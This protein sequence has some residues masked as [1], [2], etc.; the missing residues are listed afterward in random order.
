MASE[1][2]EKG[3]YKGYIAI[4]LTDHQGCL[5]IWRSHRLLL[6]FRYLDLFPL[7]S[8]NNCKEHFSMLPTAVFLSRSCSLRVRTYKLQNRW[9]EEEAE[10]GV[11]LK[12][13]DGRF[14]MALFSSSP[15]H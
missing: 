10:A 14:I 2:E 15:F 8:M 13:S 7:C 9:E 1:E 6:F 11:L 5:I 3:F 12:R 4:V